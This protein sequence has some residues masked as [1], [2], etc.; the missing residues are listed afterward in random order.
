MPRGLDPDHG[1]RD[2]F[3]VVSS[4]PSEKCESSC[5]TVGVGM[6]VNEVPFRPPF[7]LEN[8]LVNNLP[9]RSGPANRTNPLRGLPFETNEKKLGDAGQVADLVWPEFCPSFRANP[10]FATKLPPCPGRR[11]KGTLQAT[12]FACHWVDLMIS[13]VG[14]TLQ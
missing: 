3:S 10:R 5:A 1:S 4:Y 12:N 13:L 8:P 6:K 9:F 7:R 2:W 11:W 14:Q